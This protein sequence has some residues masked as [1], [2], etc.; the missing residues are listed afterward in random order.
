MILR[1]V[2]AGQR[3]GEAAL[4]E[5]CLHTRSVEKYAK[6]VGRAIRAIGCS[7]NGRRERLAP[8]HLPTHLVELGGVRRLARARRERP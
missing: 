2:S 3:S 6:L 4:I 8:A 5:I 7:E 1:W